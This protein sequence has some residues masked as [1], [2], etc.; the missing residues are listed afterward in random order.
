MAT[1]YNE[2]RLQNLFKKVI[3]QILSV[4]IMANNHTWKGASS[5]FEDYVKCP[6]FLK[7]FETQEEPGM[8]SSYKQ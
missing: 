5:Y 1:Y 6:A 4:T 2:Y 8:Y 3:K 7:H